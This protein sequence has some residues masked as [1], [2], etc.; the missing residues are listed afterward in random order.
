MTLR[1][2][3]DKGMERLAIAGVEEAS[4]DA[5]YL[6]EYVTGLSR[7]AFLADSNQE[8]EEVSYKKYEELIKERAKRIPLQHLTGVQEFMGLEFRVNEHVLIPRQDTEVLVELALE[9]LKG[10]ESVRI[11]D[12]CTGSGCILLSTLYYGRQ[13]RVMEG[14]GVDISKE[15]LKVAKQNAKELHIDAK[16]VESNLFAN[17][18]GTYDLIL[19]N[20]PYIPS[21]VIETLQPEVREHDP[22]LALDGKEDGLYF[23]RKIIEESKGSLNSGG[24]LI[25]EIGH[26]QGAAV[27]TYMMEQGFHHVR[28]KKDL[29]GLDRVVLGVYDTCEGE[30]E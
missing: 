14:T 15:A 23:Y 18:L 3:Y 25:F 16:F 22:M 17:V 21:A 24:K 29:A 27:S 9:E 8:L 1:E 7:A 5:W 30:K 28:V 12:M 10:M 6:L 20:P 2:A 4:L 26:D 13:E 19:S 11:L